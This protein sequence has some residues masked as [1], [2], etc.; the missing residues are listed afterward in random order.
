LKTLILNGRVIDPAGNIDGRLDLF[1]R[2]GVVCDMAPSLSS[3]AGQEGVRII[4]AAGLVAAPGLVDMHCHLRDPGF[5]YKE[6][7]FSGSRAA[8][9]GGFTSVACMPNTDPPADSAEIIRYIVD[10]ASNAGLVNVYPIGAASVGQRGLK[11]APYKVLKESGAVAVSD[12]GRPVEDENLMRL[13]LKQ[14]NEAGLRVI[15]H[16]EVLPLSKGGAINEGEVSR[17]LGLPGIPARAEEEMVER[18]ARLALELNLPVHIAHVST[19]GSVEIV[20]RYKA[21]GAPVTCETCPHYM[22]LDEL[23]VVSR[24]SLAKMNPPLRTRRDVEAVLAGLLDGTIDAIATDHAPHSTEEKALP[25]SKAPNGVTGL[26]TALGASLT[27]LY[28]TGRAS[29][30]LVLRKLT[31]APAD[32]LGINRGRLGIGL[33]AD[34]VIFSPDESR[35]VRE[36]SFYSK[37]KN[38][39]FIGMQLSGVVRYTLSGG[40]IVYENGRVISP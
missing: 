13:A 21:K 29:L 31:C 14:A 8:C 22:L 15:S 26:E 4:D 35:I 20:R 23:E 25:L 34:I 19:A 28:H 11:T 33:P 32:I 9:A 3:Y 5:E 38:S 27:A 40:R 30:S 12:D 39:C 16:C 37:G 6:D 17:A 1:I 10:K 18:D 24:G 36:G 2:D 7:I